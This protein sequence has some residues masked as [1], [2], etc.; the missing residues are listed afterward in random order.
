MALAYRSGSSAGNASGGNLSVNKPTGVPDGDILVATLYREAGTWTLPS[1]WAQWGSD[2][3]DFGNNM[4]LTKAWKRASSEPTSWTFNLST[5]TWRIIVIAAYSGALASG[6]PIDVGPTGGADNNSV[7]IAKSITTTVANTMAI[8]AHGNYVGSD[9]QVGTSS[10]SAGPQ[11]GGCE[12]WHNATAS[13]G[14]TGDKGFAD[15][16]NITNGQW[17]TFHL[18]IKPAA[19]GSTYEVSAS[20]ARSA[21]ASAGGSLTI[22]E[23]VSLGRGATA[24]PG[25]NLDAAAATN[26]ARSL[27]L[28]ALGGL[29]IEVGA[30]LGYTLAALSAAG[31]EIGSTTTLALALAI[32]GEA[33]GELTVQLGLSRAGGL[34]AAGLADLIGDTD[35]G[36]GAGLESSADAVLET[37]ASLARIL[38]VLAD[39]EVGAATYEA[40]LNLAHNQGLSAAAI[41]TLEGAVS[42]A[43]SLGQLAAGGLDINEAIGLALILG[44]NAGGGLAK[45]VQVSL[46]QAKAITPAIQ[47]DLV[48]EIN[49]SRINGT[50]ISSIGEL[51][52][53]IELGKRLAQLAAGGKNIEAS[54]SL[55]LTFAITAGAAVISVTIVTPAARTVV[56]PAETRR[57]AIQARES[58]L[59]VP[60]ESRV[61]EA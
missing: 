19:S 4:Y 40:A 52:A 23:G 35:L 5:T 42:L 58:I 24:G 51:A 8:A 30:S 18:A 12:I 60:A 45:D 37:G 56:V 26:L 59:T 36:R 13:T 44:A 29:D 39:G 1:G 2:Q 55:A 33:A 7:V 47:A 3:R 61:L 10:Y 57:L 53:A 46:T 49:L 22:S 28:T 41:A 50:A 38:A 20:L 43:R 17:A 21:A 16:P 11:L 31:L 14:A 34:A 6:D 54:A 32:G 27:G 25:S 15:S 9:I 48:G